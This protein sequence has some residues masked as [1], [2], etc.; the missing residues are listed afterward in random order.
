MK[1]PLY[2]LLLFAALQ[3]ESGNLLYNSSFELGDKGFS[4]INTVPLDGF[5]GKF[6][7]DCGMFID[8]SIARY[9][10]R[11][12]KLV[13]RPEQTPAMN[14]PEIRLKPETEYVVSFWAKSDRECRLNLKI[15][16]R[17]EYKDAMLLTEKDFGM[18]LSAEWKRYSCAYRSEKP[19]YESYCLTLALKGAATVW[20]DAVQVEENKL[21]DYAP[22]G[23]VEYAV[24]CPEITEGN[25]IDSEVRAISYDR[26]R[27]EKL[28]LVMEYPFAKRQVEKSVIDVR[29]EKAV[30]FSRKFSMR[31]P[32]FGLQRIYVVKSAPE[33]DAFCVRLHKV[34]PDI[35]TGFKLGVNGSILGRVIGRS[36]VI[37]NFQGGPDK[38]TMYWRYLGNLHRVWNP[39][40][41]SWEVLE[42]EQGKFAFDKLDL[43]VAAAE[44]QHVRLE[45]TLTSN[46]SV[47][48]GQ[49]PDFWLPDWVRKRDTRGEAA[50]VKDIQGTR[51]TYL[52]DLG[53]WRRYVGTVAAR[54]RGRVA[55]YDVM[56]E[57]NVAMSATTYLEYLKA[58]YE[59]IKKAD[60]QA[61][62]IGIS[63]T[64]DLGGRAIEYI[65]DILK[66]GGGKYLDAISFHPY[67]SRQDDSPMP[68]QECIRQIK[69][70]ITA[71]G[72][73][74]PL[75]NDECYYQRS[76]P[77]S[78]FLLEGQIPEGA[79]SRRSI[80]DLGEGLDASICLMFPNLFADFTQPGRLTTSWDQ[81]LQP[82]AR[83]AELNT[84]AWF[85][86]GAK[87]LGGMELA[88]RTLAYLFENRGVIYS[89]IWSVMDPV[90][91]ALR[92]PAA[93]DFNVCDLYGNEIRHE[94]GKLSMELHRYP[95]Y[96]RWNTR[97]PKQIREVLGKMEISTQNPVSAGPLRVGFAS[98]RRLLAFT[99][100][101]RNS[102]P[103]K[104]KFRINSN[105]LKGG[106]ASGEYALAGN[107]SATIS[108]PLELNDVKIRR[109]GV[110]LIV[111][112]DDRLFT[113]E[114]E[115]ANVRLLN[116]REGAWT[117]DIR[118]ADVSEGTGPA[119]PEDLSASFRLSR[120]GSNLLVKVR[121]RDDER[122]N[123]ETVA[124][125][126][127]DSVEIFLDGKPLDGD[128]IY[129]DQYTGTTS[130]ITIS[131]HRK[132]PVY[133][134]PLQR[135]EGVQTKISESGGDLDFT[136]SIPLAKIAPL[137]GKCI[138]FDIAVDDID[139]GGS[140]SQIIWSGRGKGKNF[141]DRSG[142]GVLCFE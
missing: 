124:P 119:S 80:I 81:R 131:P 89:A 91:I 30:P 98:G 107:S 54:Y 139:K 120:D 21:R 62:V 13:S 63:S 86:A 142:F 76:T 133:M 51:R 69:K 99:L 43:I 134:K 106:Y 1:Y 113:F 97:D 122:F 90:S 18:A 17:L 85:L 28:D 115:V 104:G 112:A 111:E 3:S 60:P 11:S 68:A 56:N 128:E 74:K 12:V 123:S 27:S 103:L 137:K 25:S 121:V 4:C 2:A 132:Q 36:S 57:S 87:S 49:E 130:Q 58:A 82:S 100:H 40:N 5:H 31:A 95:V 101:N 127:Q 38:T 67:S 75:W 52:P 88:N 84:L 14:C 83:F 61:Q 78:H 42:P 59:E 44:K 126:A 8:D 141:E 109:F 24:Y 108:V 114:R 37:D 93:M 116:V 140:K 20:I 16:S 64:Q 105:A 92:V 118:I 53:D 71:C 125:W 33:S 136:V 102:G 41:L 39:V 26:D 6:E 22:A 48:P 19:P 96:I 77:Q 94:P 32:L 46:W 50:P 55:C 110:K 73:D 135:I 129:P 45:L 34:D 65:R 29:L 117:D 9:G 7:A 79:I 72:V 47:T 138:G 23:P 10:K 66:A 15:S 70:T 35:R